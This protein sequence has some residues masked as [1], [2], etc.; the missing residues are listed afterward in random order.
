M[1][2]SR[3]EGKEKGISINGFG[4]TIAQFRCTVD[5]FAAVASKSSI[6]FNRCSG[7]RSWEFIFILFTE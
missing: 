1:L 6:W 2:S 5:V 4:V 3:P 7:V